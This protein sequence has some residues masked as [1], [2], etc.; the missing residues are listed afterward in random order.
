MATSV[1]RAFM[2]TLA[3]IGSTGKRAMRAPRS[4]RDPSEGCRAPSARRSSSARSR[5]AY[6]QASSRRDGKNKKHPY[7]TACDLLWIHLRG[8]EF[9]LWWRI[10]E[11][12]VQNII[13]SQRLELKYHRGQI[14]SLDFWRCAGLQRLVCTL[15]SQRVCRC[16]TAKF[17]SVISRACI[18]LLSRNR[19]RVPTSV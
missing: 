12:K 6:R 5:A 1:P 19:P 17:R 16:G 4:V 18:P 13:Y 11:V 3:N 10:H 14:H 7:A 8:L 9:Y 15:H 2:H